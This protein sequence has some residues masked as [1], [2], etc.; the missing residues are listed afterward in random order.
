MGAF[1]SSLLSM[2]RSYAWGQRAECNVEPILARNMMLPDVDTA[3][4][5]WLPAA[6]QV[7][8]LEG[9]EPGERRECRSIQG[10]ERDHEDSY[11][12]GDEGLTGETR[13][14]QQANGKLEIWAR[15]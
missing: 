5:Y 4:E 9:T 3:R 1:Y 2:P 12:Y 6:E 13:H 15:F 8:E 7:T 10:A 11:R 14:D